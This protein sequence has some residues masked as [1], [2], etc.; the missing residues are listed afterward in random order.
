MRDEDAIYT[1]VKQLIQK[2]YGK[3]TVPSI[4]IIEQNKDGFN[5]DII[6]LHLE[7]SYSGGTFSNHLVLKHFSGDGPHNDSAIMKYS[8]ESA[9]LGN[10]AI[11]TSTNVPTVYF[12]DKEKRIILMEKV[13]GMTLDKWLLSSPNQMTP[14]LQ[15]FGE[16]LAKIH[17]V[18]LDSIRHR[19]TDSDRS[20][21]N[22]YAHIAR[23][24]ERINTYEEPEYLPVLDHIAERFRAV[25]FNQDV[26]NH[27]DYHFWNVLMANERKLYILDWEKASI[28]DYRYDLANTLI[29]G[30]SWFG[31]D[32]RATMLD[33]Y[34]KVTS[35]NLQNL[36]CFEALLSFDSF[37]K[38]IPLLQG[39]DDSHIR[40]RSFQWLKRRYERFVQYNGT[41]ISQ[42]EDYLRL[43]GLTLSL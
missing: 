29:L 3:G 6:M 34:Q 33:G 15:K 16:S 43:K 21:D 19:M 11:K 27:G 38:T 2:H 14:A 9:I 18:P 39:A 37:T 30:Y 23:L 12:Q 13:E 36:D 41:R 10:P 1:I 35:K 8:K 24:R 32:F 31:I 7:F 17:A 26:L 28:N 4:R 40:E 22:I 5:N 25:S 42:A 20:K